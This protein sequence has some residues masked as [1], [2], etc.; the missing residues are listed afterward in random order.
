MSGVNESLGNCTA[1]GRRASNTLHKVFVPSTVHLLVVHPAEAHSESV[2]VTPEEFFALLV[3]LA[4]FTSK[5]AT[6]VVN[7]ESN[8]FVIL[9]HK[10]LQFCKLCVIDGLSL[11][12][13]LFLEGLADVSQITDLVSVNGGVLGHV[14]L[15]RLELIKVFLDLV[16]EVTELALKLEKLLVAILD[17]VLAFLDAGTISTERFDGAFNFAELDLV[18]VLD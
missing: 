1:I 17:R 14:T 15:S 7:D 11:F 2:G 13:L 12:G 5:H 3:G 16:V 6:D 4:L 18:L 9:C 8:I 10:S